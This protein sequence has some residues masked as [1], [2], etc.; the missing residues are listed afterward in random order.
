MSNTVIKRNIIPH[1]NRPRQ[2][3]ARKH[4]LSGK[5]EDFTLW[6]DYWYQKKFIQETKPKKILEIGKGTGTLQTIMKAG[7]YEYYTADIEKS[8]KPDY[9]A[10]IVDLP[11]KNKTF[12]TV[13]AFEVLEH[14]PFSE[15]GK[16]LSEMRR[17][18]KKYVVISLPY[19][20]FYVS[21]AIQTFYM[22]P[23][24]G[25]YKLLKIK[26]FEPFYINLALPF[27]FLKNK[28]L[29]KQ[30]AWEMGRQGYS[31]R[32]IRKIIKA[33]KLKIVKEEG[34]IFYP[35]HRFFLLKVN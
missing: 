3:D 6:I 21:F 2:P 12:D 29:I 8:L 31:L 16:A 20:V 18:S 9:I 11:F 30:H 24:A 15:F 5:Y 17:V 27:F 23:F 35:Y 32:T 13:C 1:M 10:D 22:S 34:R 26:P 25:I 4:Y 33:N 14:L 28:G 19:A 7:G